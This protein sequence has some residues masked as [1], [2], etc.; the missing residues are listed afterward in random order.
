MT[1]GDYFRNVGWMA[2]C[3]WNAVLGGDPFVSLSGRLGRAILAGAAGPWE[4]LPRRLHDH[5][6][7]TAKDGF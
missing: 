1:Y 4:M 7:K 3:F 5:F 6:V 2:S